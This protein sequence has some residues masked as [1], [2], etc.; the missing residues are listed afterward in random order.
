MNKFL[1]IKIIF[2]S[3]TQGLKGICDFA[4]KTHL[5]ILVGFVLTIF[6]LIPGIGIIL[7]VIGSLITL[8]GFIMNLIYFYKFSSYFKDKTLL[9]LP[10]SALI[11]GIILFILGI[12]STFSAIQN[13]KSLA[14][15]LQLIESIKSTIL[16]LIF[17]SIIMFIL[18]GIAYYKLGEHLKNMKI[19]WAYLVY[20]LLI[21]TSILGFIY[22]IFAILYTIL[23]LLPQIIWILA[24]KELRE[25]K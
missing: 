15:N 6:Y 8:V 19:F 3:M 20:L 12:S 7:S 10:L 21:P 9:G 13:V 5:L 16:L 25:S 18:W 4:Y 11:I 1:K 24:F 23:L 17:S 14:H 2:N 22:P